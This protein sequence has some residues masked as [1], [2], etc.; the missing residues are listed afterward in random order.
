MVL[1]Q[2]VCVPGNPVT[3]G[4]SIHISSIDQISE[5]NMVSLER[6]RK[7]LKK[8]ER[9]VKKPYKMFFHFLAEIY[10]Q[11][12]GFLEASASLLAPLELVTS[13]LE[14]SFHLLCWWQRH[15]PKLCL[16]K[17]DVNCIFLVDTKVALWSVSPCQVKNSEFSFAGGNSTFPWRSVLEREASN[18]NL[19][20]GGIDRLELF[21]P[22]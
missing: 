2:P 19:V 4:M 12:N 22:L 16:K 9:G 1:T 17:V 6:K 21:I 10:F 18:E 7:I 11:G 14:D 15:L 3:V 8:K 20:W 13:H 5:V